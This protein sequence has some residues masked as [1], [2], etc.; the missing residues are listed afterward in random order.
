MKTP[1]S[2]STERNTRRAVGRVALGLAFGAVILGAARSAIASPDADA[3]HVVLVE[4]FTSQGCSSCPPADQL[5]SAIGGQDGG[6]VVPLAFHVDFWN[7]QGWTDPFSSKQ[8]T[9][10]QVAYERQL[11]ISQVYTPQAVVDGTTEMVGSDAAH[12]RAA[13]EAAGARP[14][15]KLALRL[16][17][18]SSRVEVAVDVDL[19]DALRGKKLDLFVALFETGLSTPVGRG[20]NGGKT[21][22]NDYVVRELERAGRLSR[23]GPPESHHTATLH[24]S[25]EWNPSHL[26]VAAF[27]Q[28]PGSLA[29]LGSA[30]RSLSAAGR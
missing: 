4:L 7:S 24:V 1:D 21:L 29:I 11:G 20:E 2:N 26:G 13:I 22:R 15:A 28:D 18:S 16:E 12:L 25:K 27:L 19:P 10:R 5:L 9:L 6:R 23:D 30:A 17:P 8:W 14:G 3:G